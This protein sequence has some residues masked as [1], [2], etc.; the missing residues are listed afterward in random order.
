MRG[1]VQKV[2]SDQPQV[3]IRLNASSP[4]SRLQRA[5]T[6]VSDISEN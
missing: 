4:A 3:V 2:R 5:D 1:L 6:D